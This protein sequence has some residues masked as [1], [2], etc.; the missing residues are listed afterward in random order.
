MRER[1]KE[2]NKYK[3]KETWKVTE[4]EQA[5]LKET[6]KKPMGKTK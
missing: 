3:E 6:F 5:Y 1:K 2:K 4:V